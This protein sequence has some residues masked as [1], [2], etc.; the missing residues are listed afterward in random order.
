MKPIIFTIHLEIT[1]QKVVFLY[2]LN[3]IGRGNR[4]RIYVVQVRIQQ[5]V[6]VLFPKA[7]EIVMETM[8]VVL[9]VK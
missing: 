6:Q 8:R 3:P 7:K 4:L 9:H 5:E 1:Y 2:L